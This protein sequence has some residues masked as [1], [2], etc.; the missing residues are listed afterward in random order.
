MYTYIYIYVC[1]YTYMYTYTYMFMYTHIY[2]CVYY[3]GMNLVGLWE[4]NPFGGGMSEIIFGPESDK[5]RFLGEKGLRGAFCAAV[6]RVSVNMYLYIYIYVH[7][8]T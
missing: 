8:Y 7:I 6:P 3:I 2:I 1:I 4:A 5:K